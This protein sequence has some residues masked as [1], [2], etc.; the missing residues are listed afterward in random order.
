ML[1]LLVLQHVYGAHKDALHGNGYILLVQ[2]QDEK[3]YGLYG[4]AYD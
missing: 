1:D 2:E 3:E 4:H